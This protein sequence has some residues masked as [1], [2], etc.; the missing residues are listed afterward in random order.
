MTTQLYSI[1]YINSYVSLVLSS[2]SSYRIPRL[3][4]LQRTTK[5]V[6]DFFFFHKPLHPTS[7]LLVLFYFIFL[8]VFLFF[9]HFFLFF[10][11]KKTFHLLVSP[12]IL[13]VGSKLFPSPSSTRLCCAILY[14]FYILF[15][16]A[17]ECRYSY[18]STR[19][20]D[21]HFELGDNTNSVHAPSTRE[22]VCVFFP[23]ILCPCSW[24]NNKRI[25]EHPSKEN[26]LDT[27]EEYNH[28]TK[29]K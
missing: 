4:S 20:H 29:P 17:E 28:G 7:C 25:C 24:D 14:I 23:V 19:G 10:L 12:W 26:F 6:S 8:F 27:L 9:I 22:I 21:E 3:F 15:Y 5:D 16:S 2:S 18:T 13:F 11:F 1:L